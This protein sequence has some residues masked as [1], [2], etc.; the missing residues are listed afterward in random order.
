[1]SVPVPMSMPMVMAMIYKAS[2]RSSL[3]RQSPYHGIVPAQKGYILDQLHRLDRYEKLS[4][5]LRRFP[6]DLS[7]LGGDSQPLQ[8]SISAMSIT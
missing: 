6:T 2:D 4:S 7:Q 1:M 3:S 5:T 8:H